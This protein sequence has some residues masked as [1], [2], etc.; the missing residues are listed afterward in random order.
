M[1]QTAFHRYTAFFIILFS[2]QADSNTISAVLNK[3]NTTI[4]RPVTLKITVNLTNNPD[5]ITTEIITDNSKFTSSRTAEKSVQFISNSQIF[6]QRI[7]EYSITPLLVGDITIP[8]VRVFI[9]NQKNENDFFSDQFIIS[10]RQEKNHL[11]FYIIFFLFLVPALYFLYK[12]LSMQADCRRL[13]GKSVMAREIISRLQITIKNENTMKF[14]ADKKQ[15]F[16]FL[17]QLLCTALHDLEKTGIDMQNFKNMQ[18][19]MA[20]YYDQMRFSGN[21]TSETAA[22]CA[23]QIETFLLKE[24]FWERDTRNDVNMVRTEDAEVNHDAA[25][26]LSACKANSERN[27]L[28]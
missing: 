28:N 26:A 12:F 20:L 17:Y 5:N 27:P 8:P 11:F 1:N 4:N 6:F 23:A 16:S 2:S 25:Q 24:S 22:V 9:N 3:K 10:V 18:Q 19:S 15:Y 14:K 21:F 7:I 13:A